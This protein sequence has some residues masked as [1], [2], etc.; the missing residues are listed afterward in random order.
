MKI[1]RTTKESFDLIDFLNPLFSIVALFMLFS[2]QTLQSQWYGELGLN[3]SS[4][5][6][7]TNDQ[8]ARVIRNDFSRSLEISAAAGYRFN[9]IGEK[10]QWGLGLNFDKHQMNISS[11]ELQFL[12]YNYV[13]SYFGVE[14]DLYFKFYELGNNSEKKLSFWLRGGIGRNWPIQGVQH[15]YSSNFNLQVD[16]LDQPGFSKASDF[17]KYGLELK[18]QTAEASSLYFSITNNKSFNIKEFN[19]ER[20]GQRGVEKFGINHLNFAVGVVHDFDLFRTVKYKQEHQAQ[21]E[22]VTLQNRIDALE[23]DRVNKKKK[24]E[25]LESDIALFKRDIRDSQTEI[26]WSPDMIVLFERDQS[27]ITFETQVR[28]EALASTYTKTPMTQKIQICGYADDQT[29]D[30]EH[31]LKLS[32]KRA[33]AVAELMISSGVPKSNIEW[34]G[35][36]QT[37]NH[38]PTHPELNRRVEITFE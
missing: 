19:P 5:R 21:N 34:R 38:S 37:S 1:I 32:A 20:N 14:T 29:G 27:E 23:F 35:K 30:S 12:A 8:G 33:K 15:I 9:L 10:L 36:G 17:Y 2:F 31:N 22:L 4:F 26:V 25:N 16:L 3:S 11:H 7:Y 6:N 13:F 18:Y 24:I 28:I